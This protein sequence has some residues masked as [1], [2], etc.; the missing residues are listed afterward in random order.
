[1]MLFDLS[2]LRL[3]PPSILLTKSCRFAAIVPVLTLWL[4][5]AVSLAT[6]FTALAKETFSLANI[7]AERRELE[8]ASRV[9][10]L[11]ITQDIELRIADSDHDPVRRA[12]LYI[13]K[14]NLL[15]HHGL[16][17]IEDNIA[18]ALSLIDEQTQPELYLYAL[19]L[20]HI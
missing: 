3:L 8:M 15:Q 11:K 1:M 18:K 16:A 9:D 17:S 13:L 12:A 14:A 7:Q 10:S 2:S 19:S 20:I 4:V 5:M 6:S